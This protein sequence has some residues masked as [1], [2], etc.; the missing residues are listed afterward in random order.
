MIVN[1]ERFVAEEEPYWRELEALL[2]RKER[3]LAAGMS[4]EEAQRLYYLYQRAAAALARVSGMVLEPGL[5]DYLEALVARAYAQIHQNRARRTRLRPLHWIGVTFPQ[6]FRRNVGAFW[7]ATAVILVG[8]AFGVLGMMLDDET[9]LIV[10]PF[11]HLLGDPS[12]R[13]AMEEGRDDDHMDGAKQSFSAMLMTHNTRVAIMTMSAGI[14]LGLGS[15]VLL[16]YNGVILGA[17]AF[18]YV[19]AGESVFLL[20][21]L[22]PHGA[23][24]IPA[25]VIGG[26]AGLVLGKTII[27]WRSPL[28]LRTRLRQ[29]GPDIVTLIFGVALLLIWAGIIESFLSQYHAP[30]LPYSLKIAFGTVE[31]VFLALYLGLSGRGARDDGEAAR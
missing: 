2:S 4:Y 8:S 3:D 20:G 21:W 17:V 31:L 1:Q 27:G 11:D 26:Q 25:I 16:F 6:T 12:D 9:K 19:A 15:M 24:E 22:L 5:H 13:V 7:L 30:V 14:F 10:M 23:M 18:D 28:G 29:A